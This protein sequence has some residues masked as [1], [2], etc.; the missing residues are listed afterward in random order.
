MA[1][2][3]IDGLKVH[4]HQ[5]PGGN[6]GRGQ[7][8]IYVHGT[9]GNGRVWQQ[10]ISAI[11]AAH[12]PVA[13]DLPGHGKSAGAGFRGVA[14]YAHYCVE[15]GVRLGWDQFIVAGH[16]LGGGVALAAALYYPQRVKGLMLI[17]TGAR[18]RVNPA[19]LENARRIA[20]GGDPLSTDTR[21]G[22]APGTAQSVVDRVRDLSA[23]TDP[24]VTYKDWISDDS[25][26]FLSRIGDLGLPAI[27]ICGAADEL[28]PLKYHEYFRDHMPNCR[29][30]VIP[31]AA[32]WS[33]VEQPDAFDLI[34]RGFLDDFPV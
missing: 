14:D 15:L 10:H 6:G 21:V 28:T 18:L 13:I 30:A 7:K 29:L 20:E 31:D 9:G 26:D 32:H 1:Y 33:Y 5:P 19:I 27:A 24:A 3:E 12:T 16:S 23:D 2:A 25:C 11:A 17:D 22:F 4:Y 34:V 8:V